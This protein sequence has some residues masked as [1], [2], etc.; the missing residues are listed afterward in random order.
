MRIA[1]IL[2]ALQNTPLELISSDRKISYKRSDRMLDRKYEGNTIK[3]IPVEMVIEESL[4]TVFHKL[5]ANIFF[6]HR[7]RRGR[8]Q[9]DFESISISSEA[10]SKF[11]NMRI[12]KLSNKISALLGYI[13]PVK[14]VFDASIQ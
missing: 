9:I 4:D 5:T 6:N 3:R 14:K 12:V 8:R 2:E 11:L 13:S 7:I 10:G 1:T